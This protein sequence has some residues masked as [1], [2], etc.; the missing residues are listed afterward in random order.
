MLGTA[1]ASDL[2]ISAVMLNV[3]V[4]TA[5][6]LGID[7]QAIL[8]QEGIVFEL[9]HIAGSTIEREQTLAVVRAVEQTSG[10]PAVSLLCGEDYDFEYHPYVKSFLMSASTFREAFDAVLVIQKLI[11]PALLLEPDEVGDFAIIR[12]YMDRVLPEDDERRHAEMV[13]ACLKTIGNRLM[14]KTI[15]PRAVHFRHGRSEIAPV[16]ADY[17]G[18]PIMLNAPDNAMF[19]DRSLADLPLPGGFPE[20]H[21]QAENI[22]NQQLAVSPLGGDPVQDLKRVLAVRGDLLN[23]PVK[24]VAQALNMSVRTLQR[25]LAKSDMSWIRLRD[26]IRFQVADQDLKSSRLTIDEIYAKLGFSD[27]RSF[28]RAFKR[29]SNLS[30]GAYRK[31]HLR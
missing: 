8:K 18:C 5:Q 22:L 4:T 15:H 11:S 7:I 23:A 9:E 10:N 31:R 13:F 3:I 12:L 1:G 17:F 27:R 29:W 19:Y 16:Y 6:K 30:P 26:E 21:K 2:K 24:R 20:L 14:R 25:R 28:A